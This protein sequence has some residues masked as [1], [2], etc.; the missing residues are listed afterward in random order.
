M[1]TCKLRSHSANCLGKRPAGTVVRKQCRCTGLL[2]HQPSRP[3]DSPRLAA[4]EV[5]YRLSQN[6]L[7][8]PLLL[9]VQT[10]T[11]SHEVAGGRETGRL[12]MELLHPHPRTPWN[13]A[14]QAATRISLAGTGRR[15]PDGV[16]RGNTAALETASSGGKATRYSSHSST[17]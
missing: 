16:S 9:S 3:R 10:A 1:S 5:S 13:Q 15:E 2:Q 14:L 6:T 11:T 8:G 4:N 17:H 7:R 12:Y